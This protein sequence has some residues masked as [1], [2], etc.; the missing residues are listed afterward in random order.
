VKKVLRLLLRFAIRCTPLKPIHTFLL[1]RCYATLGA[2]G[3]ETSLRLTALN[4]P[5]PIH[6]ADG[7]CTR[8]SS[9]ITLLW[10]HHNHKM[11][12]S[13]HKN[14]LVSNHQSVGKWLIFHVFCS[15]NTLT[16]VVGYQ[17]PTCPCQNGIG[18]WKWN[19]FAF[20]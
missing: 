13:F 19:H 10:L 5:H 20:M 14:G 2:T 9:C 7:H 17:Q 15:K 12:M 8:N 1:R 18:G 11:S 6:A 16:K 4:S 3:A